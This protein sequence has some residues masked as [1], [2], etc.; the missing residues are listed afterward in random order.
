LRRR[1]H[2][3]Q[4]AL[5][6]GREPADILDVTPS[7]GAADP[8]RG[9]PYLDSVE[10][11]VYAGLFD[12]ESGLAGRALLYDRLVMALARTQRSGTAVA[13]VLF[14]APETCNTRAVSAAAR[15]VATELRADDTVAR[16]APLEFIAVCHVRDSQ[17]VQVVV[18]RTAEVFEHAQTELPLTVRRV[19]GGPST[20]AADLLRE[21]QHS[22]E[23]SLVDA[24][25]PTMAQVIADRLWP[26]AVTGPSVR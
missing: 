14:R 17:E 6:A 9:T 23:T 4:P 22:P 19:V 11:E 3:W 10:G 15:K 13:V 25:K 7:L 8:T 26:P 20:R 2:A 24:L 12:P 21:V 1:S 16:V 18:R 5:K